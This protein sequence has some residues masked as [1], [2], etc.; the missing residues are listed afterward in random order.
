MTTLSHV[1]TL[2]ELADY[3]ADAVVSVR[4]TVTLLFI[5]LGPLLNRET[6]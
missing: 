4:F 3:Q 2:A 6:D 5:P 1:H